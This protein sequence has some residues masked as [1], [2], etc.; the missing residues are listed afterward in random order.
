M[1]KLFKFGIMLIAVSIFSG[2]ILFARNYSLNS[3]AYI[4]QAEKLGKRRSDIVEAIAN[5]R[6]DLVIIDYSLYGSKSGKWKKHE[7]SK[8]KRGRPGRK[9]VAYL[10][11]GEAENYRNYWEKFK[12][13]SFI[14]AE[15]SEWSGNYKVK[16]WDKRWQKLIL[17][18]LDEIILQGFDGVYLDIVDAFEFYEERN[19]KYIDYARNPSTGN[20]YRLDMVNWV[21][22]IAYY[23]RRKNP[24]FLIIPQNGSQ[25]LQYEK[26]RNVIDGIGIENLF[27]E[28]GVIQDEEHT[29]SILE[30]FKKIGN[31]SCPIFIIEYVYSINLRKKIIIKALNEGFVLLFTSFALDT[32]GSCFN[33]Y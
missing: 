11:I 15:N 25:L 7:I 32:V 13:Y 19:G 17:S 30:N 21:R 3:L 6:R 22:K 14:N 18:Y 10:S 24:K 31:L 16:Y 28:N 1:N 33:F 27:A 20:C 8:I 12:N 26:Y 29:K 4:L 5:C 2:T 23:S 9:V